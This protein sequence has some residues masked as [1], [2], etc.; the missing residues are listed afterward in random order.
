MRSRITASAVLVLALALLTSVAVA[1]A[2]T[3]KTRPFSAAYAGRAVVRA[4]SDT[5][6][7]IN[8]TGAGKGALIG[9]SKIAA[10]GAGSQGEPCATFSGKGTITGKAGK[11]SFVLAPAR[12][13]ARR[14][15][16]PT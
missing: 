6:A 15:R 8:V 1:S 4:T 3:T 12:R 14:R 16:T 7:D 9:A 5:S 10:V 2:A 11:L 13:P